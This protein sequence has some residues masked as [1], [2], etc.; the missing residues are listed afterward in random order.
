[1]DEKA[2]AAKKYGGQWSQ[3]R[4]ATMISLIVLSAV[5]AAEK[6]IASLFAKEPVELTSIIAICSILVAIGTAFDQ[7]VKPGTRWR[8]STG[9][10]EKFL[11]LKRM[12]GL[13]D[14]TGRSAVIQL[15][16][17]FKDLVQKWLDDTTV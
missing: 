10:S 12:A 9:Y 14:A 11:D 4:W 16:K 5:V 17:E 15:D 13:V 8:L 6:T 1:M 7:S 2:D 3:A